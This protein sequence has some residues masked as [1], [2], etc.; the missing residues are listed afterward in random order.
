MQL[1]KPAPDNASAV[2]SQVS[3]VPD[4]LVVPA[5]I[6][7]VVSRWAFDHPLARRR[8]V[9]KERQRM[10]TLLQLAIAA[11]R[12]NP[13]SIT[14]GVPIVPRVGSD[15]HAAVIDAMRALLPVLAGA[16]PEQAQR[17]LQQVVANLQLAFASVAA[18]PKEDAPPQPEEEEPEERA[19]DAD[20]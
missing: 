12:A 9:L 14:F 16:I 15:M 19:E 10:A 2:A 18:Q 8:D 20:G 13:V 6:S 1:A 4:T 7:G 11:Y 17:D 3:A 5:A